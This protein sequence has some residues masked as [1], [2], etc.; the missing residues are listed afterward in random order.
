MNGVGS[1]DGFLEGRCKKFSKTTLKILNAKFVYLPVKVIYE[2]HNPRNF[3][4]FI[5]PKGDKINRIIL[6][7][8]R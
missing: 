5:L 1:L 6:M 4:K 3:V 7:L 2:E 8:G